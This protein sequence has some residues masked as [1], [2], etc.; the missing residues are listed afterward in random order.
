[1]CALWRKRAH[2]AGFTCSSRQLGTLWD[3]S[4]IWFQDLSC[5]HD[6]S[7]RSILDTVDTADEPKRRHYCSCNEAIEVLA[8]AHQHLAA[9]RGR[10]V[11]DD[12]WVGA[13]PCLG[14]GR[15]VRACDRVD[16]C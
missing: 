3:D 8:V 15:E 14:E 9:G 16:R 5:R 4:Q 7:V 6:Q 13:R 11:R 2:E 12:L 10:A 1:M